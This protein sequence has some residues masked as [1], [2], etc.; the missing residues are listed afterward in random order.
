MKHN[1]ISISKITFRTI[2]IKHDVVLKNHK[3]NDFL[4]KTQI[5]IT[6]M[7]LPEFSLKKKTKVLLY[8]L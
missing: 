1:G 7:A 3:F 8:D 2:L 6:K 4:K 5:L